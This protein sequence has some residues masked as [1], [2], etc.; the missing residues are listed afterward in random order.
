MLYY[1]EGNDT[2]AVILTS[3]DKNHIHQA[4][5]PP[6]GS[7]ILSVNGEDLTK[8]NKELCSSKLHDDDVTK[9]SHIVLCVVPP[10]ELLQQ[11]AIGHPEK[12]KWQENTLAVILEKQFH[13]KFGFTYE[14]KQIREIFFMILT[15]ADVICRS[16]KNN[17][18]KGDR[19]LSVNCEPLNK[20][21]TKEK[22]LSKCL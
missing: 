19:I 10:L 8:L 1:Q 21:S 18:R 3:V 12:I 2:A 5:S 20:V 17:I 7:R 16:E 9:N 15:V 11:F 13:G 4:D 14:T 22:C 6:K